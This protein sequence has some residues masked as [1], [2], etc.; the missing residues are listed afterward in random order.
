MQR[1][2]QEGLLRSEPHRGVFVPMMSE[3]D[4]AD[5]YFARA[6]LESAAVRRIIDSPRA[7]S[8]HKSLHRL[9]RAMETA[10]AAGNWATF[11]PLDL[12]F[13][14]VLVASAGSPRLDRM[15]ST[16]IYE[17]RLCL[18]MLTGASAGR[19]HLVAEHRRISELL[20]DRDLPGALV[21]LQRHFDEAISTL[22]IRV[23]NAEGDPRRLDR[24]WSRP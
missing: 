24:T 5:I 17:T 2:I 15:F 1:L 12:E 16:V 21:A 13:H 3:A 23:D 7:G 18:G 19:V 14:T 22:T 20:R 4:L 8:V 9:V 11:V 10:E 6:A